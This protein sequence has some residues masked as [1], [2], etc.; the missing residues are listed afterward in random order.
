[1]RPQSFTKRRQSQILSAGAMDGGLPIGKLL[2][3][4]LQSIKLDEQVRMGSLMERWEAV[5]GKGVAAHTRPGRLINKE[6]TV[7]VDSSVWLS[8]L[9]RYAHREMLANLQKAFGKDIIQKVRL[10]LDPDK[11]QHQDRRP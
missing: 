1:M 11:P 3:P 10:S 2:G 6:I 8:E 7:F 4:F 9:Q 5:L